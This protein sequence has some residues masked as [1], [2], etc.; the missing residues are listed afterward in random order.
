MCELTCLAFDFHGTALDAHG[1]PIEAVGSNSA[2]RAAG[3]MYDAALK[4][5]Y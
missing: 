3:I 4:V 5:E 1:A 2:T